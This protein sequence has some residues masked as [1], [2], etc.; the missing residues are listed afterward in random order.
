M[1]KDRDCACVKTILISASRF[2][3]WYKNSSRFTLL[4]MDGMLVQKRICLVL[5]IRIPRILCTLGEAVRHTDSRIEFPIKHERTPTMYPIS[6]KMRL[7]I[8]FAMTMLSMTVMAAPPEPQI[9]ERQNMPDGLVREKLRL[10]GFDPDEAVPAIAIHPASGGPFPVV[11][12]LHCFRGTKEDLEPWCRDLA[13][14]GVFAI[15]I[16][17]HLHGER[18]V[19]GIFR[20]DNI[21]S[22]EVEYSIW[23]H[24]TSIAHTAKD[25]SVILDALAR[26]SDIDI[27][28]V[29]VTG[30]SMGGSTAMVIAW[31]EPRIRVVASIVGA[32]DFWWDVTKLPPGLEQN[33][34][35]D[36]YGSRLRELV[37]SIDLNSRFNRF[38]P[39]TICLINGGRDEYIDIESVRR[40]VAILK[41]LYSKNADHLHF[42]PFPEAGHEV[43][44]SMWQEAQEWI[45]HNL[46]KEPAK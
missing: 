17:A 39:K 29:A 22:L 7:F 45:V 43:T 37:N 42:V 2:C 25:V 36:S 28:R 34:R 26:R 13:S 44:A 21:A 12:C 15:S 31:R 38:P 27:T 8:A 9:L 3:Y 32:V 46:E 33:T 20:G 14:R 6:S 10:P 41:P 11:I 35:K 16:D 1:I 40:F 24:Q 19:A 5:F 30:W 18:S 23:V 4:P